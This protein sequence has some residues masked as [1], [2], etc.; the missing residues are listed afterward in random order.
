MY[1]ATTEDCAISPREQ[2]RGQRLDTIPHPGTTTFTVEGAAY[3]LGKKP[4]TIYNALYEHREKFGRVMYATGVRG[5]LYRV[6]SLADFQVLC[7]LFP[8]R[9]K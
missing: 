5:R 1:H 6:L 2:R 7:L 4:K 3:A 9:V 8:L